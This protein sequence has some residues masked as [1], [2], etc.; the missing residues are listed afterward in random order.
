MTCD[1]LLKYDISKSMSMTGNVLMFN[2]LDALYR[3]E[4]YQNTV[5]SEIKRVGYYDSRVFISMAGTFN[6]KTFLEKKLKH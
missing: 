3:F 2:S 5:E 4:V 1:D 6:I